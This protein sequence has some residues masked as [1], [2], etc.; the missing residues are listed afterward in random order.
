VER[1]TPEQPAFKRDGE[2]LAHDEAQDEGL[3]KEVQ[4]IV[5]SIRF[6]SVV[7]VR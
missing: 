6:E 3:N 2:L 1:S 4:Q 5:E 7:K